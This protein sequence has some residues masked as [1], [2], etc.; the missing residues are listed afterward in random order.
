MTN[1]E[2]EYLEINNLLYWYVYL[3]TSAEFTISDCF[4]SY[5]DGEATCDSYPCMAALLAEHLVSQ[6]LD[7]AFITANAAKESGISILSW[8]FLT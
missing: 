1:K 8:I 3:L 5:L 2:G 4:S 7:E 6:I